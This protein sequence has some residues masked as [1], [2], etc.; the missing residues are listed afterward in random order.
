MDLK[1]FKSKVTKR[2]RKALGIKNTATGMEVDEGHLGGYLKGIAAP[3]TW[4]EEIWDIFIDELGVE[5][6]LDIGCGIGYS[7]QYFHNKN[8]RV[9]GIEGSPSALKDHVLPNSVIKHD[10]T[11]APCV[12]EQKS[13]LVWSAEFLEHVEEKYLDNFMA[14]FQTAQKFIAVTYATPGQGGHHHVNENT[15]EYWVEK[16]SKI[17]AELDK[18]L[19]QRARNALPQEGPQGRQFRNKGLIFRITDI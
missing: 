16:F 7:M 15:E 4:C 18:A 14:S 11:N 1:Q 9:L 13:D 10:Y 3:G 19:T 8:C 12:P 5:S 17:G 2:I 6:M